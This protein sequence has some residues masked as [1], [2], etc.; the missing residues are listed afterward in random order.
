MSHI[1][2]QN[3]KQ[4]FSDK[5]LKTKEKND[6]YVFRKYTKIIILIF[7]ASGL[8]SLFVLFNIWLFSDKEFQIKIMQKIYENI[9]GII[10]F[11]LSMLGIK[12]N[13]S[14]QS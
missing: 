4:L 9:L 1:S 2:K 10:F 5:E 12:L 7:L 3:P 14:K 6:N 11:A 13:N 8:G